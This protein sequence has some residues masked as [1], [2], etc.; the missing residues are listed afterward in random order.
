MKHASLRLDKLA[1]SSQRLN[2]ALLLLTGLAL[3]LSS[4]CYW[5]VSRLLE[6]EQEKIQFH[7]A[8][9]VEIIHEHEAFLRN[10]AS[11]Y[12]QRN[13]PPLP[14]VQSTSVVEVQRDAGQVVLQAKG[15]ALSLPFTLS[16]DP[17]L[18]ADDTRRALAFGVQLTDYYGGYWASSFYASPQLFVLTPDNLTSLAVPGIGGLRQHQPLLPGQYREV[19]GRLHEL[20]QRQA[21]LLNDSRVRWMRAPSQLYHD[22][23]SVV[24]MIG[25]DV[26]GAVLPA[27]QGQGLLALAAVVD[28]SQV[29]EFERVLRLSVYNQFTLIAPE[30]DV[31][32]GSL[33]DERMAP[34]GLSFSRQGLRFK[35]TSAGGERWTGLYAI[36]YQDFLR[37]AK[38]PL[39]GLG[40]TFLAAML[41]GWWINHWYK[42]RI[43]IPAQRAQERLFESEAFNRIMLHNAP[44]GLCVVRRSDTQGQ[45]RRRHPRRNV[46]RGGR[47]LFAGCGGGRALRG[48]RR[49]SLRLQRHHAACGRSPITEPGPSG[50]HRRQRG[51]DGV[52]RDHEP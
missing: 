11:G 44:A 51:Q 47:P 6:A 23:R 15:F 5:A 14:A 28:T 46:P 33:G 49:I 32:L 4:S 22:S 39:L 2:K 37:Y 50:S 19:V 21:A 16:H 36:T 38:W 30:G 26:P 8:R 17:G 9:V 12:S 10:V 20:Q 52:P 7:F 25:L 43:V 45:R 31:L 3:L 34:M 48:R 35:M 13:S 24:A 42:T 27:A 29:D 18:S 40:L 1:Q 41:L